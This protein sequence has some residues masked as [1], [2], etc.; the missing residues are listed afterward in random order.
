MLALAGRGI[1]LAIQGIDEVEVDD[2]T[3]FYKHPEKVC[4]VEVSEE[5]MKDAV[6]GGDGGQCA[7]LVM[8]H[9]HEVL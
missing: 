8:E 2:V 4:E 3:T 6:D 5:D 1:D 7:L 9:H